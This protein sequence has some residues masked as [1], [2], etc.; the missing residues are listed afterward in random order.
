[1]ASGGQPGDTIDASGAIAKDVYPT[2]RRGVKIL[3]RGMSAS[4]AL[5]EVIPLAVSY[6]WMTTSL[7][8]V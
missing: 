7:L 6:C 1:M 8:N 3:N 2:N 5:E 4:A